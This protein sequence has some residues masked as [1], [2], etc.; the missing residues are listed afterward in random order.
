MVLA[1]AVSV[2]RGL[3][4]PADLERFTRLLGGLGLPTAAAADTQRV[5]DAVARDKKRE[6][7]GIQFV[8]LEGIGRS[9]VVKIATDELA[10]ALTALP[11]IL[12]HST[13]TQ[14]LP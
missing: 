8:L 13:H 4:A 1:G 2:K 9:V 3:L 11:E 5:M 6:A 12:I 14:T 10:A 7:G